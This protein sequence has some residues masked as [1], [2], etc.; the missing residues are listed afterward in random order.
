MPGAVLIVDDD[1]QVLEGVRRVLQ[2]EPYTVYTAESG[3]AA[4]EILEQEAIDV[5]V[6]DERMPGL[7]GTELLSHIKQQY[8]DIIRI[9]LTGHA[10]VESAME[11]IYH[12]W[13]FQYL[14]KPISTADLTNAIRSGLYQKKVNIDPD[15]QSEEG[16]LGGLQG[17][18]ESFFTQEFSEALP[19]EEIDRWLES[20]KR[21][22]PSDAP[23]KIMGIVEEIRL[24]L[25]K[26][27]SK[28]TIQAVIDEMR[29]VLDRL[30]AT[31]TFLD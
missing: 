5:V 4:I 24:A 7:S 21:K 17:F 11:A 31:Q 8:P 9:M 28:D 1:I 15:G 23:E 2:N 19:V 10:D 27:Q 30:E 26:A 12:D 16:D 25:Y 14:L 29:S 22:S 18:D 20:S 6:S 13:V 3:N